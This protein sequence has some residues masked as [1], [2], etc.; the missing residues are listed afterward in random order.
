ML[1]RCEEANDEAISRSIG[2]VFRYEWCHSIKVADCFG[3]KLLTIVDVRYF[4]GKIQKII[5]FLEIYSSSILESSPPEI[6][7]DKLNRGSM[8]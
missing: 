3:I 4:V 2:R 8:V 6:C 1:G 7:G 5:Y